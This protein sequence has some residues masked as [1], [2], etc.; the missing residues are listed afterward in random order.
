[1]NPKHLT[2]D[3]CVSIFAFAFAATLLCGCSSSPEENAAADIDAVMEQIELSHKFR[4]ED[5]K[6]FETESEAMNRKFLVERS[7][8]N[9]IG[10]HLTEGA[11][12]L[13]AYVEHVNSGNRIQD[14]HSVLS[15]EE[16]LEV[17]KL[18]QAILEKGD[19]DA[20]QKARLA[21]NDKAQAIDNERDELSD[22]RYAKKQELKA[23]VDSGQE[24]TDFQNAFQTLVKEKSA[25]ELKGYTFVETIGSFSE[26][27]VM[28]VYKDEEGKLLRFGFGINLEAP[29]YVNQ[30]KIK[31]KGAYRVMAKSPTQLVL[32]TGRLMV[33]MKSEKELPEDNLWEFYNTVTDE[34]ELA[35]LIERLK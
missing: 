2:I 29:Q 26:S 10:K 6:K 31:T 7:K 19:D 16:R 13:K 22:S 5:I 18:A 35:Q 3:L 21:A 24:A 25:D 28:F 1:M 20:T 12:Q 17:A 11:E 14:R 27:R 4:N 9:L 30:H 32:E 8:Q 23:K 34:S 15:N 33:H